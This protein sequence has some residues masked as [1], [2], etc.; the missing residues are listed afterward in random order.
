MPVFR[1]MYSSN[2][3]YYSTLISPI[4]YDAGEAR[5]MMP[6]G[7]THGS[8]Q[9]PQAHIPVDIATALA[10]QLSAAANNRSLNGVNT[11]EFI[12]REKLNYCSVP[13]NGLEFPPSCYPPPPP[14]S[15]SPADYNAILLSRG[16]TNNGNNAFYPG[17]S[18]PYPDPNQEI[19]TVCPTG[20]FYA[21]GDA[22][23]ASPYNA[24][25]GD[26]V[27]TNASPYMMYSNGNAD[28]LVERFNCVN[29]NDAQQQYLFPA[30]SLNQNEPLADNQ[31]QHFMGKDRNGYPVMGS[32][33]N[34][35]V[36]RFQ[37]DGSVALNGDVSRAW[38]LLGGT[39]P[40][41]N[42]GPI[43]GD[44]CNWPVAKRSPHFAPNDLAIIMPNPDLSGD[45]MGFGFRSNR[46]RP[47]VQ[48][49][50]ERPAPCAP[51]GIIR[52]GVYERLT[53]NNVSALTSANGNE[54][55]TVAVSKPSTSGDSLQARL[56]R[57]INPTNF[58]ISPS[59]AR[60]FVIKSFS[61]DDIHRSIK[62]SIWCSTEAGNKKLNAAYTEAAGAGIPIYLFFSV[63]GSGHF[64][65][66]AEMTSGV[67]YATRAG[68]WAQD[69]WQG[70]FSVKWI[71]VKDVSNAVLRHIHLETND[72]KPV[73]HSRDTTEVPLEQGQQVLEIFAKYVNATSILDDFDYYERREQQE[74][75]N[76]KETL[77]RR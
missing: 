69:K 35:A 52:N 38:A 63:N 68:V 23:Q 20:G 77:R 67:D 72:N 55:S 2:E 18:W 34:R 27:G 24:Q 74:V 40:P 64:C 36:D 51:R 31:W 48:K 43:P 25:F 58:N 5:N 7:S 15:N 16:A 13:S 73:T 12:D 17:N 57:Q 10:L 21:T 39:K 32:G 46:H 37:Q 50:G 60:F 22:L 71:F 4:S 33:G 26:R 28:D 8:E 47:R 19:D 76:R 42:S 44:I 70:Q 45:L 75:L 61:E 14:Q 66:I 11:N 9:T 53:D 1:A 6:T 59:R 3:N 41:S 54:S 56:M 49:N 29:L 30:S 65:G 62:Y